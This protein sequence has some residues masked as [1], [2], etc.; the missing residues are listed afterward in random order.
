VDRSPGPSRAATYRLPTPGCGYEDGDPFFAFL[1][2]PVPT[3]AD[4][5]APHDRAVVFV[6]E[7]SIKGTERSAQEYPSPLLVL[8]GEEYARITF[9]ELH[10]RLCAAL[11]GN[12]APV[13]AEMLLPHGAHQTIRGRRQPHE[14]AGG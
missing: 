7:Y 14:G 6:T 12:R 9:A 8:T 10:Q 13:V 4:G 2:P 1:P 3:D 11:R 5:N